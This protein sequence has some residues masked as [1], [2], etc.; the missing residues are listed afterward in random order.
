MTANEALSRHIA[1]ISALNPA[2]ARKTIRAIKDACGI[3]SMVFYNWMHGRTPIKK[4]QRDEITRIVKYDL[5][6]DVT[7]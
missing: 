5:F 1:R 6:K 3:S 2:E 4:L 7:D